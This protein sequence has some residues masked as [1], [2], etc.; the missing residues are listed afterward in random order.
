MPC[1]TVASHAGRALMRFVYAATDGHFCRS[2]CVAL[3]PVKYVFP[4]IFFL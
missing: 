1:I 3:Q 2:I 4:T